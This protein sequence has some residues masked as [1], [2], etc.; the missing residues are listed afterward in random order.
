MRTRHAAALA[1]ACLAALL[2]AA[3]RAAI[4]A[5]PAAWNDTLASIFAVHAFAQ[6]FPLECTAWYIA[7]IDQPSPS[8]RH[9][10]PVSLYVTAGH[11]PTPHVVHSAGG[12]LERTLLI[13][14]LV[15]PAPDL[16][17]GAR[18]DP[19]EHRAFLRLAPAP[20]R[21]GARALVAGYAGGQLSEIILTAMSPESCPPGLL[22]FHSDV[23]IRGGLSGA[24]IVLLD[25]GEAV[26]ML[27]AT[28]S[29]AH[30][31]EDPYTVLAT[32]SSAL[33]AALQL[34]LGTPAPTSSGPFAP[35][36]SH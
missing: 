2:C 7:P 32:P 26:G 12:I 25:T 13:A 9:P 1:T 17:I 23:P 22:C 34:A 3:A 10:L 6:G 27:I 29:D 14:R 8:A 16:A 11:C 4:A 33:R 21:P 28:P 20:P 19:R 36:L 30:G 31:I 5:A 24:P 18:L 35:A 15:D